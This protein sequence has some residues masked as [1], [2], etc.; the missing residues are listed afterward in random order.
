MLFFFLLGAVDMGFYCYA[1]IAVQDAARTVALFASSEIGSGDY[2][3]A[4]QNLLANLKSMPNLHGVTTCSSLPLTL[5]VTSIT[6]PDGQP[7][8]QVMVSYQT[9]Q[10]IPLP[11]VPG[12]LTITRTVTARSRS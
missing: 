10:L 4:C 2:A 5:T 3:D 7:A 11:T 1:L 8:A 9:I 6:G 12:R